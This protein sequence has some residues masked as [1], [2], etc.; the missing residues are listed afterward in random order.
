MDA[1]GHVIAQ[2]DDDHGRA[3]RDRPWRE[4][5]IKGLSKS[6]LGKQVS[7]AEADVVDRVVRMIWGC[8]PSQASETL[9]SR[10]IR[11]NA[12]WQEV[13]PPEPMRTTS[14]WSELLLQIPGVRDAA[15][16]THLRLEDGTIIDLE[17]Y[18]VSETNERVD[19]EKPSLGTYGS[20][21]F[22]RLSSA[23]LE[24]KRR[25]RAFRSEWLK[26]DRSMEVGKVIWLSY[27]PRATKSGVAYP[28]SSGP[29]G[30]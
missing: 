15:T 18:L 6:T 17:G 9:V 11:L 2:G 4:S 10:G 23:E 30:K 28:R 14:E 26:C 27:D 13:R 29:D 20:S 21:S 25:S 8:M 1:P 12:E 19:L 16:N 7:S 3:R 24:L 22:V 5:V